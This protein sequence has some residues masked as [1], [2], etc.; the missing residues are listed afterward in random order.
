[1]SEEEL[2]GLIRKVGKQQDRAAFAALFRH[3]SPRIA[4][5]CRRGGADAAAA[6][7]V[8]Q[9]TMTALWRRAASFDPVRGGANSWVFTIVR[10]RR[11]DLI[12]RERRPEPLPGMDEAA[13]DAAAERADP[14][15]DPAERVE[16]A[17][18]AKMLHDELRALPAEQEA[19]LRLAY[20]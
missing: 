14:S 11:I 12:R 2:A 18:D 5:Y 16:A 1:V 13:R 17:Q 19:V 20:F 9:E 8:V 3:Y 10:N 4:A 15:P 7:E 6:D